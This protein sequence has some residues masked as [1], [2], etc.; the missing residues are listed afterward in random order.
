M[1]A[2][3]GR[4]DYFLLFCIDKRGESNKEKKNNQRGDFD[5]PPLDF[6][7]KRPHRGR[8][9]YV[10]NPRGAP[11]GRHP[12]GAGSKPARESNTRRSATVLGRAM[13]KFDGRAGLEPAPTVFK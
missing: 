12:V 2:I 11:A 7:L 4:G 9:P 10:E 3:H 1:S 5:F 8:G 6:P 13:R